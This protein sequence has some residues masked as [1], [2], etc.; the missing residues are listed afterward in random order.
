M[1]YDYRKRLPIAPSVFGGPYHP[2][3]PYRSSYETN[4]LD[5]CVLIAPGLSYIPFQK[6]DP[7]PS[8]LPPTH[9]QP[10]LLVIYS[11]GAHAKH[12]A[13]LF[14]WQQSSRTLKILCAQLYA[15]SLRHSCAERS[16]QTR[17]P[18]DEVGVTAVLPTQ[19]L[20][21]VIR[22]LAAQAVSRAMPSLRSTLPKISRC[23]KS[24]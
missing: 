7:P 9:T 6:G 1:K 15:R 3:R 21:S 13:K 17:K 8:L 12:T 18:V 4:H 24:L 11:S 19:E 2:T 23:T 10:Y 5:D 22:H 20:F 14:S 16:L